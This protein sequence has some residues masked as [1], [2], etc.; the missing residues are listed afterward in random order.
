MYTYIQVQPKRNL[1]YSILKTFLSFIPFTISNMEHYLS[2]N[3][4]PNDFL[5]NIMPVLQN[6]FIIPSVQLTL[7]YNN[8]YIIDVT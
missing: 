2:L 4:S 6:R 1:T 5:T 7:I 8:F 3:D